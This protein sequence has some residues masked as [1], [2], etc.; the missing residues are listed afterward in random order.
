MENSESKVWYSI[1]IS[2]EDQNISI[3]PEIGH[4]WINVG[5]TEPD[6]SPSKSIML[7][8]SEMELLIAK[9]E[10]MMKYVES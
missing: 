6:G 4:K 7:N 10:E 2:T 3:C 5:A 8:R 9:M 1:E